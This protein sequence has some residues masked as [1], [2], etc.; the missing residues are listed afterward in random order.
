MRQVQATKRDQAANGLT[1]PIRLRCTSLADLVGEPELESALTRALGKSFA[2]A[3]S[4]LPPTISTGGGVALMAPQLVDGGGLDDAQAGALLIRIQRAIEAAARAQS[5]GAAEPRLPP[6]RGRQFSPQPAKDTPAKDIG[7]RFDPARFDFGTGSYDVPSYQ[8]GGAPTALP[9]QQT[10]TP[11]L[12]ASEILDRLDHGDKQLLDDIFESTPYEDVLS[13]LTQFEKRSPKKF[14]TML[15]EKLKADAAR[16]ISIKRTERDVIVEINKTITLFELLVS[17]AKLIR[18]L[19]DIPSARGLLRERTQ[20]DADFARLVGLTEALSQVYEQLIAYLKTRKDTDS[21][22]FVERFTKQVQEVLPRLTGTFLLVAGTSNGKALLPDLIKDIGEH[23]RW[24][25]AVIDKVKEIDGWIDLYQ[26]LFGTSADQTEEVAT[27]YEARNKYLDALWE[28]LVPTTARIAAISKEPDAFY[29]DWQG[30]AGDRKLEKITKGL[31][32]ARSLMSHAPISDYWGAYSRL[33]VPYNDKRTQVE[34]AIREAEKDVE[35]N[36]YPPA[37]NADYLTALSA[38]ERKVPVILVRLQLLH[39]WYA[40]IYIQHQ[41]SHYNIGDKYDRGGS[42]Y[43]NPIMNTYTTEPGWYDKLDAIRREIVRQ[44]DQPDYANLNTSYQDWQKR[45]EAIQDDIKTTARHEFYVTL[46]IAIFATIVTA[47]LFAGAGISVAVV[48]AEA[49]TFTLINTV[50]Q[51]ALLGK[52]IDPGDVIGD[53]AENAVMFGAFK[54]LNI[55]AAAGAKAIAPGKVLAQL[56]IVFTTT[57]VVATGVPALLTV[58]QGKEMPEEAKISLVVN[59]VVNAA[60]TLVG[61]LNT[62]NKIRDLQEVN[63]AARTQL[64]QDLES[65][66]NASAEIMKELDEF[67]KSPDLKPEKF[68]D[69][70]RRSSD[71]LPK[72]EKSLNRLAGSEF[73]DAALEKLG[74]TRAMVQDMARS[75]AEAARLI[76]GASYV[77]S[78]KASKLPA[79]GKVV[80]D[81]VQTSE[82]TF[83]YNPS[84]QGRTP[85]RVVAARLQGAGYT[86]EDEGG[87]V[88]KVVAAKGERPILMLPAGEPGGAVFQRGLLDRAIGYHS[89]AET[90]A[91]KLD[92]ERI[93]RD[94]PKLLQTEFTDETAVSTLEL[95]VEQ[96]ARIPDRWSVDSVRGLAEML[97]LERGI[98]RP[99]IRKLFEALPPDELAGLFKKYNGIVNNSLVRPGSNFLVS[100]EMTPKNSAKLIEAY[101]KIRLAPGRVTLPENMTPKAIQGLLRWIREGFD[102]VQKLKDITPVEQRVPRLEEDSP[103]RVPGEVVKAPSPNEN[104]LKKH[105]TPLRPGL[106]LFEGEPADVAKQVEALGKDKGGKFSD[107]AE[108]RAFAGTIASYRKAIRSLQ[109]G[110]SAASNA[111]GYRREIERV[112][113]GLEAGTEVFASGNKTRLNID[114]A[115]FKLPRDFTVTNAAQKPIQLDFGGRTADGV[116]VLD[117]VS[118]SELKLP[119]EMRKLLPESGEPAGGTIDFEAVRAR[120]ENKNGSAFEASG[121]KFQQMIKLRAAALFAKEFIGAFA[122]LS[123]ETA[124]IALPEMVVNV[125]KADPDA[126]AVAAQLGFKVVQTGKK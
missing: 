17:N 40:S 123:G 119:D 4:A 95:L 9:V 91:I 50:G 97:K 11:T 18:V 66:S 5:L 52:P 19:K 79:P 103:I 39:L 104:T 113:V 26:L 114:P 77:P 70:K 73:S 42:V 21:A 55:L 121:R 72:F 81:L 82:T 78:S 92:L 98:T 108:R 13:V 118:T 3:R 10:P 51:A 124:S 23:V 53:F 35:K 88:L 75:V 62:R 22:L 106:N 15:R 100:E 36:S 49:G 46:G 58:I 116:I 37:R 45:L 115:L 99:A 1:F 76:G 6:R 87:G 71:V 83:E 65:Q 60:M 47:G 12:S 67:I 110:K 27:L 30:Q 7:E 96:R 28:N 86:V 117:E 38:I 8:G 107:D 24:M 74:L 16:I 68:D 94:L 90:A 61:G 85:E 29:A 101:D 32:E 69:L 109:D 93:Y 112:I 102:Y 41:V 33:D 105:T 2:K 31:T 125:S 63:L 59:L 20:K 126:V 56:G 89:E 34:T 64:I 14:L 80:A 25:L 48:L 120:E 43:H 84:E 111:A 44:F 122:K 54:G 57:T